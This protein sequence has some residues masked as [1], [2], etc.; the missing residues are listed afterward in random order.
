MEEVHHAQE[1]GVKFLYL[2]SPVAYHGNS[3]GWVEDMECIQMELSE[4]DDSGRRRPKPIQGS[5]FRIPVDTVIVAIGAKSNDLLM[6]TT[7]GL[8]INKDGY[9]IVDP[10]T[11]MTS[12]PGIF[13]GGDIA[14]YEATVISA[15][16][17][18]RK[19]AKYMDQYVRQ[20]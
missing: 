18:G 5:N 3:N 10:E 2:T 19:A 12:H 15:M 14:S 9:L 17:Q 6:R 8:E 7:S 11:Q 4:P 20:S 1:E 13:A 16:G